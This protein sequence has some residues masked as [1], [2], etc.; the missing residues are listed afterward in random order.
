MSVSRP[1]GI[2]GGSFSGFNGYGACGCLSAPS[3]SYGNA[4]TDAFNIAKGFFV[5]E[6]GQFDP[7][8]VTKTVTDVGTAVKPQTTVSSGG[9]SGTTW[10]PL[11]QARSAA[12]AS[13]TGS[14]T[15]PTSL[16][17]TVSTAAGAPKEPFLK[18]TSGKLFVGIG[19]LTVGYLVARQQRWI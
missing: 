6:S 7:S 14:R 13:Q 15:A 16:R 8:K 5:D 12:E 10:D 17:S 11:A 18:T 19:A 2:A 9:G 3:P 4:L 1:V